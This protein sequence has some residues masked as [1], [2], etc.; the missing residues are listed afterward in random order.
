MARYKI[1]PIV[2]GDGEVQ[3]VPILINRWFEFRRFLNFDTP[4]VAVR[5]HKGSLTCAY[6]PADGSGIE[7]YVTR[8]AAAR[9]DGILVIL[10]ADDD[11]NARRGRPANEQ[12]GPELLQRAKDVAGHIPLGVVVANREFEAWFLAGYR[13]L[14]H[15]EYFL[16]EVRFPPGF[17]VEGPR[18][19]KGRVGEC[20]GRKYSPTADQKVLARGIGFKAYMGRHSRSFRKLLRDLE[21]IAREARRARRE[22]AR[23]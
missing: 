13:R 7:Y 19:C 1:V 16:K 5:A 9:P 8:A 17:D 14:K 2:E 18:D 11:C 3:A 21:R 22:R 6:D 12:L 10:D 15:Q 4:H 20:M 23:A